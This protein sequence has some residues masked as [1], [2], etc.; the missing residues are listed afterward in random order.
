MTRALTIFKITKNFQAKSKKTVKI[1]HVK[2]TSFS[3]NLR[4][5]Q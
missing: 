1:P 2:K 3:K 4:E 5:G